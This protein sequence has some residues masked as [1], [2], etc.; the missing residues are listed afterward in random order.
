MKQKQV[1]GLPTEDRPKYILEAWPVFSRKPD[2]Y[3]LVY[4]LHGK[5]LLLSFGTCFNLS[6]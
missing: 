6:D 1:V 5:E 4:D 2:L 3:F